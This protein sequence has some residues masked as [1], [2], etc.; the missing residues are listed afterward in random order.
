MLGTHSLVWDE[1]VKIS[2]ADSDFHRRDLWEA[3][4]AGVFPEYELGIQI[5]SEEQAEKFTFDIL[6]STKIIPEELIPVKPTGKMGLNR[7]PDNFFAETEQ[8]AF[9]AGNVVPGIDET[10]NPLLAGRLF[11]YFDTQI[12]LH[13]RRKFS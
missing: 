13:W 4:E 12:L 11:S 5:F 7:S 10:N 1:A 8:V 6:D 9:C 3:I 2:G